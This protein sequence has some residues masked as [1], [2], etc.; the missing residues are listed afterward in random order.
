MQKIINYVR[1][2]NRNGEEF[3]VIIDPKDE[4]STIATIK[5]L[6][7]P[8]NADVGRHLGIK[9]YST[10]VPV[11]TGLLRAGTARPPMYLMR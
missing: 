10:Y 2:K 4:V 11:P 8:K 3:N 9:I 1:E 6:S 5:A 7:A